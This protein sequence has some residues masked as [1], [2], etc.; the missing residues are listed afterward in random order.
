MPRALPIQWNKWP[1]FYTDL[2]NV[3]AS[4]H[5]LISHTWTTIST[6]IIRSWSISPLNWGVWLA[7]I[8]FSQSHTHFF[9][10]LQRKGDTRRAWYG[11]VI[12]GLCEAASFSFF[13]CCSF[14]T[15]C[16]SLLCLKKTRV[17]CGPK[18][19]WR[20]LWRQCQHITTSKLRTLLMY[21]PR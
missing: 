6:S 20:L 14:L 9:A 11:H 15:H 10:L 21:Y 16:C 17:V 19:T 13:W 2:H 8:I 1:L 4:I 7:Q 5:S 3:I 18:P 12:C